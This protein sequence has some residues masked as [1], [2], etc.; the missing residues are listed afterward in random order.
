MEKTMFDVA[1]IGRG[2]ASAAAVLTFKAS[3]LNIAIIGTNRATDFKIG[4]MLPASANLEL[5]KLGLGNDFLSDIKNYEAHCKFSCW[6][7]ENLVKNDYWHN[8]ELG[9]G[10]FIDRLAFEK[11]LWRS[12]CWADNNLMEENVRSTEFIAQRWKIT[13]KSGYTV[14]AKYIIDCS[15]RLG[16]VVRDHSERRRCD[17]LIAIY[18]ILEQKNSEIEP[19]IASLTES[20]RDGWLYTSLIPDNK[21]LVVFFTDRDLV[22]KNIKK[23]EVFRSVVNQSKHSIQRIESANFSFN[24]NVRV[25]DASTILTILPK[26]LNLLAAGDSVMS[27]D[28]LSSNGITHALWSGRKAALAITALIQDNE[29]S[30]FFSYISSLESMVERY[31]KEKKLIY[32]MENRFK[33]AKFWIRRRL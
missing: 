6:G 4:E 16:A 31:A 24:N 23:Q 21:L 29:S 8:L 7:T 10:H 25:V 32:C 22:P 3:G 14:N 26:N 30:T 2:I 9:F 27:F 17:E 5:R 28:P 15:G 1:V 13:L 20:L 11:K 33:N 12:N 19:S 18:S